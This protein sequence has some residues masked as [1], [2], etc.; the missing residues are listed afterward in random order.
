MEH[1]SQQT[2]NLCFL[3]HQLQKH[4]CKPDRLLGEIASALVHTGHVIPA[5]AEGG[6]NRFQHRVQPLRQ[7]TLLRNFKPILCVIGK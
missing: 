3:G 4:S 7:F 1:E 5:N 2:V 6:V